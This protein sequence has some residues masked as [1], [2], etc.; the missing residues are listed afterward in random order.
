VTISTRAKLE[1]AGGGMAAAGG[2]GSIRWFGVNNQT[3]NDC[4]NFLFYTLESRQ[5]AVLNLH[6]DLEW[7][8]VAGPSIALAIIVMLSVA[9]RGMG[10]W[11][12]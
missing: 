2:L 12:R 11:N 9:S 3:L 6:K 10:K 1:A 8:I 4:R 7:G 5:C